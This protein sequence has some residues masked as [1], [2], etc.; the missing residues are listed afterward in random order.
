MPWAGPERRPE[1][2][3]MASRLVRTV[4]TSVLALGVLPCGGW[5]PGGPG[6]ARAQCVPHWETL[7]AGGAGNVNALAE[8]DGALYAGGWFSTAGGQAELQA[9]Q[10]ASEPSLQINAVLAVAH[11]HGQEGDIP[12]GIMPSKPVCAP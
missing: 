11:P 1:G 5:L 4:A 2:I 8:Y 7:G 10:T 3:V 6:L 12:Q 9:A